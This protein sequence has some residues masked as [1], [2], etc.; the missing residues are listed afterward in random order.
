MPVDP[1]LARIDLDK[2]RGVLDGLVGILQGLMRLPEEI[3]MVRR[4]HTREQQA[5]GRLLLRLE[6]LGDGLAH[7]G[8]EPR[9]LLFQVLVVL[10][11]ELLDELGLP[12]L[13]VQGS[14]RAEQGGDPLSQAGSEV[15][16]EPSLE[17]VARDEEQHQ[18]LQRIRSRVLRLQL[19]EEFAH[20]LL[21]LIGERAQRLVNFE[22]ALVQPPADGHALRW[23]DSVLRWEPTPNRH[24]LRVHCLRERG[25]RRWHRWLLRCFAIFLLS[26]LPLRHRR[27]QSGPETLELGLVGHVC[28][29]VSV[30][31]RVLL[32]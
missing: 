24:A 21:L 7:R 9:D 12:G 19:V 13:E 26:L 8:A 4:H 3:V 22:A 15:G 6:V 11:E 10:R 17:P 30:V 2:R 32:Q 20:L 29:D 31:L 25:N 5:R 27:G 23:L 14:H 18:P 28:Q 1:C 16:V